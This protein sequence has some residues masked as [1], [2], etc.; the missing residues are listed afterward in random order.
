M[1]LIY[2]P[3][4]N[5]RVVWTLDL[6]F[7][8]LLG[9]EYRLT[10]FPNELDF[11]GGPAL[12]YSL[13]PVGDHPWLKASGLLF[14]RD[15]R[16]QHAGIRPGS[17]KNLKTIFT[18]LAIEQDDA[19]KPIL[20]FDLL[21]AVFYFVTRYEEYLPFEPDEH[22][23]FHSS[24]SLAFHL[25]IQEEPIVN[26]WVRAFGDLLEH[27]YGPAI[28][29]KYPE[30][31]YLPTIDVDNAWAYAHKGFAR[32]IGGLW[33]DRHSMEARNFRFQ[34][35]R[36]NQNDPF[37]TYHLIHHF[38]HEASVKAV[39]FFLLGDYGPNDKN[40]HHANYHLQTLIYNISIENP[41]GIHPSYASNS[42][43]A[44][45]SREIARLAKITGQPVTRSRQHFL[46]LHF[47]ETCRTL[48]HLGVREDYSL[49]YADRPGFRG[50]I[51]SPFRFFDLE[52]NQDTDL[53]IH[54]FQV[55]DITLRQYL[56]LTPDQAIEKV[57]E[58]GAKVKLVGGTFIT[59]WHNEALSEWK[60]WTGWSEV[61]RRIV[62]ELN[63]L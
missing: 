60:E 8:Q 35:L 32:F 40:V 41:V 36:E 58:L 11:A 25:G 6:V 2:S 48:A 18:I 5:P 26:Q 1:I 45:V 27:L 17:W 44:I 15:I 29:L 63:S 56:S 34:V 55:M 33:Q 51:A 54:P 23:R 52:A 49:G 9:T 39:W 61:Y 20:N 50:G 22:N 16:E 62:K 53:T 37:N 12:A 38:H 43:P 7:R 30:Y 28:S 31:T 57:L 13:T 47:P 46:R 10:T 21:S 59:L 19:K 3:E 24:E 14:E 42:S 4:E